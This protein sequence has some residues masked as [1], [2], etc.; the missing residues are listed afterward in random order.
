MDKPSAA[1]MK[2][3]S[4]RGCQ[5]KRQHSMLLDVILLVNF[6]SDMFQQRVSQYEI[7]ILYFEVDALM[8]D[9]DI[10]R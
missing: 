3:A 1:V 9:R 5:L 8:C 7:N 2:K 6:I 10:L 4:I